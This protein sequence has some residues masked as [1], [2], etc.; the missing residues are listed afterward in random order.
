MI[1]GHY[2]PIMIAKEIL[3][4]CCARAYLEEGA[5][6]TPYC[7]ADLVDGTVMVNHGSSYATGS[8]FLANHPGAL[9]LADGTICDQCIG[10]LLSCGQIFLI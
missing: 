7:A 6:Q 2:L 3:C 10:L 1:E 4:T 8:T 9:D 5:G